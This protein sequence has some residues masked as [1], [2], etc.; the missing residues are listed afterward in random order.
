MIKF[1]VKKPFTVLVSV[2]AVLVLGFVAFS[3][4]TPDL[5]PSI[6]LPYVVLVTAYPGASPEQVEDMVTR[7]LEQAMA[8]L[9]KIENVT[10]TSNESS[11]MIMMEFAADVNMDT[12]TVDI[13]QKISQIEGGWDEIVTT[14]LILKLNPDMLP[15]MVAAV[16]M[17][18]MD[19][20]ALSSFT[21]ETLENKL[22]GISGVAG[23]TASGIVD[24]NI[25]IALRQ[26]K[27]DVTN[28]RIA[29][30]INAGFDEAL[31][32]LEAAQSEVQA[33]Q[34]AIDAQIND[35]ENQL[36]ALGQT[37]ASGAAGAQANVLQAQL[38]LAQQLAAMQAQMDNLLQ[39]EQQL[40]QVMNELTKLEQGAAAIDATIAQIKADIA[41]LD[42]EPAHVEQIALDVESSCTPEEWQIIVDEGRE[43]EVIQASDAYV[44]YLGEKA[45]LQS[46]YPGVTVLTSADL[47]MPLEEA[48]AGKSALVDGIVQIE[49]MLA[50]PPFNMTLEE[51]RVAV[52]GL[53][54]AKYTLQSTIAQLQ[55]MLVMLGEGTTELG[56]ATTM[57]N[58]LGG[59]EMPPMVDMMVGG[60]LQQAMVQ[61]ESGFA[62]L[63]DA[64]RQALDA[65]NLNKALTIEVLAQVLRAQSFS[66]PAGYVTYGDE[67]YLVRV[68]ETVNSEDELRNLVLMDMGIEGVAPITL[69]DV[70]DV[71][72]QS[73][74]DSLYAKIN[75]ADGV[76]LTFDKQ[77]NYA[78]ANVS[79]N[80]RAKFTELENDYPGLHFTSLMDQGD[81]IFLVVDNILQNLLFGAIFAVII[82]FLFLK[83][84]RPTFI[85]LC[86]IPISVLFAIVLM[87]FSG[88][89]LNIIS[90]S[91]LAVAVGMLVD[92]SVVVIENT[93]RLRQKGASYVQ[94]AVSGATQVAGAIASSTLTTV[95]VFLPIV[96]VQ[97]LTRQLFTDMA[98]TLAYALIAS[99]VVA[100]TLVPA[101]SAG[102][103]RKM[104]PKENKLL[105][106]MLRGYEK[107]LRFSLK[108][109]ITV[110]ALV[111]A[112]LVG[113]AMMVFMRGFL[114]MPAMDMPQ[115]DLSVTMPEGATFE[116]LKTTGDEVME[117]I[118]DIEGVETVGA[119]AGDGAMAG[120]MGAMA[121]MFG[122]GDTDAPQS[123]TMYV[124]IDDSGQY[125]GEQIGDEIER[126]TADI[127]A[128]IDISDSSG[129]QL[130]A[131]GGSGISVNVYGDNTDD[132]F[133]A[134]NSIAAKLGTLDGIEEVDNGIGE[135]GPEIR[136]IVDKEKAMAHGLTVAQVYAE[137]SSALLGQMSSAT[138]TWQG[139]NYDVMIAQANE[140]SLTPTFVKNLSF[141]TTNMLGEE[142]TLRV[143][144]IA[145]IVDTETAVSI[146]R[147]N[148]RRLLTVDATLA[149]GHNIT[150]VASAAERA[151]R[152]LSLPGGI[153]YEFT[154]ENNTIMDSFRDLFYMIALG[155]L[156]VYLIM[157]AQ[158]QSLKSP[159]IVMFTIPLAFTGGFLALLITGMELS[160]VALIGFVMLVGIIVNNGI[161]LVDYINQLRRE[162]TERVQ[163]IC[164]AGATR[165]R[166]ILMTTIT[167]VLGLIFMA[168]GVGMGSELMQPIAIVCIGG[169]TY[170]TIM[171]LFVVP[172]LYDAMNKK[173][174]RVVNEEELEVIEG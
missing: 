115:L 130:N 5:L 153:T 98:L 47:Q 144:S 152:D 142:I 54:A 48:E 55:G 139:V 96:F 169:L 93:F 83:D 124:I 32:E 25:N 117:R 53:E 13:L 92:N 75:G 59:F 79:E 8:T 168:V 149:E 140:T 105:N 33:Q 102:M 141:T 67:S 129:M 155:I 80:I 111:L 60:Q 10:S 97:G 88:I 145:K 165:M 137:V 68:G 163:A 62:Q 28:K 12:T 146:T 113:S 44:L 20:A 23:V 7:P 119:I 112:L 22:E 151:L 35:L 77:S 89:T 91:G 174:L 173:E 106:R 166:P 172:V 158:F 109:K 103:F 101:M 76:L 6:E 31:L 135:T 131:L 11:S 17:D 49:A 121:G 87:Y 133:A 110:L 159:F 156:L 78:T 40:L 122:G 69:D 36:A 46:R 95:C 116:E 171:T 15:V 50:A 51:F 82:L 38:Q 85:T 9:E 127:D 136:I 138:L 86:S 30:A 108:H 164:E 123:I 14:P 84:L 3:N 1:S 21:V 100:L 64:R 42:A 2:I 147:E 4:M 16:E 58:E 71:F 70:A 118:R 128:E 154:G 66:M 90:L 104:K 52:A 19:T 57:L 37:A 24:E 134:V 27:I 107:A 81:Y 162:G 114:F 74:I 167:T 148:Q 126:V 26:D 73:N 143:D 39:T 161:V 29:D 45:A 43:N 65:A 157:V 170:A 61:I 18:G 99:L 34:N 150:L 63:E 56:E 41:W 120:M 72:M 160:V 94:A 125:S 132:L